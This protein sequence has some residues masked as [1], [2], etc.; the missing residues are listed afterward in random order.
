MCPIARTLQVYY[1]GIR[2]KRFS[3]KELG[4]NASGQHCGT[5]IHMN[6]THRRNATHTYT[7]IHT[8]THTLQCPVVLVVIQVSLNE[9]PASNAG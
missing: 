1:L 6:L 3:A 9:L 8:H 4:L 2:S 7:H 5:P